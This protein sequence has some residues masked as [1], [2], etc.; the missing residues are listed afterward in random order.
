M[1]IEDELPFAFGEKSGFRKFMSKACPQFQVPSRRTCTRDIVRTYFQGRAKL[2]KFFKDSCQRVSVTTYCWTSQQQDGYMTVTASF[3]GEKWIL[4]K[5]VISFFKIKGNKGND[6]GKSLIK[7]LVDW[8][9][10]R[11]MTV[12][13]DNASAN[14][15]AIGY[16]R[17]QLQKTT[18]ADGKYLH[19]RCAAHIVNLITRDGLKDVD[20]S[21]QRVRDAVRYIKMERQGW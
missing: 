21:V 5:K 10:D 16:L 1:L 11:I 12:T 2:K 6:I 3:I 18:I 7:S 15:S 9:L 8:G 17:R 14:D 13:V 19:M 20:L 4:Q